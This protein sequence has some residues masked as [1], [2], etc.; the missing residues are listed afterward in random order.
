M[1]Q[2]DSRLENSGGKT[3]LRNRGWD[4]GC[5][6]VCDVNTFTVLIR[7]SEKSTV[8]NL[9]YGVGFA[10]GGWDGRLSPTFRWHGAGTEAG[11]LGSALTGHRGT[12]V[13][14]ANTQRASSED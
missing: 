9:P 4:K 7:S 3:A 2:S 6:V 10:L 5:S 14:L 12:A 1:R 11:R 8:P 13:P